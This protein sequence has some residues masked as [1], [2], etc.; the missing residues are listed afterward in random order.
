V[1]EPIKTVTATELNVRTGPS[2][3]YRVCGGR[4]QRFLVD[5]PLHPRPR[6][7]IWYTAPL[8]GQLDLLVERDRDPVSPPRSRVGY[9]Q[10]PASVALHGYYT[11]A[12]AVGN[13]HAGLRV[14]H[15]RRPLVRGAPGQ[16]PRSAL[17]TSPFRTA[18]ASAAMPP[19]RREGHGLVSSPRELHGPHHLSLVRLFLTR[20]RSLIVDYLHTDLPLDVIFF[21]DRRIANPLSYVSPWPNHDNHLH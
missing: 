9:V 14:H 10:L 19:P 18:G 5:G 12:A 21:N 17:G 2:A 4:P 8:D 20:T 11:A 15:H 6:T 7:R 3:A 1:N 16:L 13:P